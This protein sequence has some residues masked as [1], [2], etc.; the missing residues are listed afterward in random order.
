[1]Y[2]KGRHVGAAMHYPPSTPRLK[3]HKRALD[4]RLSDKGRTRRDKTYPVCCSVQ[5]VELNIRVM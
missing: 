4:D 5:C 1:M 3:R 2:K